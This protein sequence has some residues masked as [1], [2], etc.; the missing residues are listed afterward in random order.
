MAENQWVSLGWNG[1]P[2][3]GQ[4]Q[5]AFTG[6][7]LIN[8]RKSMGFTE[9]ITTLLLQEL[10]HPMFN[11]FLGPLA[12]YQKAKETIHQWIQIQGLGFF[13]CFLENKKPSTKETPTVRGVFSQL[14]YFKHSWP[15]RPKYE[16]WVEL[17]IPLRSN[18]TTTGI[19]ERVF[20]ISRSAVFR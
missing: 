16:E 5:M 11:W 2:I 14:S 17:Q 13:C 7:A 6:G 8:G 18:E 20:G 3:N 15:R 9:V 12:V 10:F 4:K 19:G 1:V